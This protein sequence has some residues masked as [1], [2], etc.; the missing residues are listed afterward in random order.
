M[1]QNFSTVVSINERESCFEFMTMIGKNRSSLALEKV[2]YKA[3]LF[4]E[5]FFTALSSALVKFAEKHPSMNSAQIAMVLPDRAVAQ[6]VV[7]VPTMQAKHME[8]NLEATLETQYK[9]LADLKLNK[10]VAG[11]NRQYTTYALSMIRRELVASLYSTCSVNKMAAKTL[12]SASA[13]TACAVSALRPKCKGANYLFLDI[14][15]NSARFVFCAKERSTGWFELPFGY[16]SLKENR[17]PQEDMLFDHSYAELIVL[18]AKEKARQE[19]LTM[20]GAA[21]EHEEGEEED[22]GLVTAE[23]VAA[24][25][26]ASDV[27]IMRKKVARKLPKFMT[28]PNPATEEGYLY[29]NFRVFI[30]WAKTL[31]QRNPLLIAQGEPEFIM[32]NLPEKY[33]SVLELANGDRE[34]GDL[35][36]VDFQAKNEHNEFVTSHLE[37]FGAM[38]PLKGNQINVF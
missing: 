5:E 19:A 9:N 12:I 11:H 16:D 25:A 13:S 30:K 18:N 1:A 32:V 14:K 27:K 3:R 28:R 15:E 37:L 38:C 22:D 26:Q 20:S 23:S 31:I 33:C 36:F 17:M 10:L 8:S 34:E 24:S 6:D 21:E 7:L 35:E 2:S 4:D 29:E